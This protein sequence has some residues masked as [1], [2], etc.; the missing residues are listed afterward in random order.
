MGRFLL[1]LA[2]V[3]CSHRGATGPEWPKAS[4]TATDG[5]ESI[6]PHESKQRN[7]ALEREEDKPSVAAPAASGAAPAAA[8]E[9][10][11]PAA[12][13]PNAPPPP[14]DPLAGEDIVIEIDD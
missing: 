1:A 7:V 9:V 14:E 8:V 4:T 11:A 2:L 3:G 10:T 13:T 6:A 12:V 5:G